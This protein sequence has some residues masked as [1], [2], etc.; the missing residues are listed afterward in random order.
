MSGISSDITPCHNPYPKDLSMY[1]NV[2]IFNPLADL[3]TCVIFC[4]N[5]RSLPLN[6]PKGIP[7]PKPPTVPVLNI[8]REPV[9]PGVLTLPKRPT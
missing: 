2:Y 4:F 9:K 8:E 3:P 1:S 6:D 5:L 7:E